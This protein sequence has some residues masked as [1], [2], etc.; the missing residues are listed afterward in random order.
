MAKLIRMPDLGTTVDSLVINAWLIEPGQ[1]VELGQPL[2]EIETD[3]AVNELESVAAGTLLKIVAETGAEVQTGDVIA[4]IGEPG[5][6][7]EAAL[8][9]ETTPAVP[10]SAPVRR[11]PAQPEPV[12]SPAPSGE[13]V[14]V[15]G[16]RPENDAPAIYT[17]APDTQPDC[18]G[19]ETPFLLNL[20]QEMQRIRRFEER[21]RLLFLE[22]IMPGTIH[23]CDGQEA[24]AVGVC[25]TLQDGD[26]ITST[27]RPHGHAVARGLPI[28]ELMSEL[29]GR[30]DGCCRG[31]GGSMHFGDLARGM[32]PAIATVGSNVPITAGVGLAFKLRAEER[33]AVS[34]FGDG[35]TNEGAF[36]EGLNLAAVWGLPCIFVCENNYYGASTPVHQSM[37]AKDIADRAAAYGI[38][39]KIV[40]GNDVLAVYEAV[41]AAVANARAGGGP[42]FLELKTYRLCGH[43]RRDARDYQPDEEKEF[44]QG[45]E[46]ISRLRQSMLNAGLAEQ[47]AFD[48]VDAQVEAELDAA[49]EHAQAAPFPD[50]ADALEHVWAP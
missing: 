33:V 13:R 9:G 22:G 49:I 41:G 24:C 15:Q 3:K 34:F 38:E 44:W 39:G 17:Y 30:D 42:A 19:Y 20:Y 46:P 37:A 47:D 36:H 43:S 12:A 5:E 32:V 18:A 1:S 2:A 25:A 29:F 27:H 4:V 31:K 10:P 50:G 21:V 14:I 45:R 11:E 48:Q 6:D 26:V 16:V 7:I 35:A 40:D 28:K 8:Q 23:Q